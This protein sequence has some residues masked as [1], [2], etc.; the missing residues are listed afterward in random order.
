MVNASGRLALD[1]PAVYEALH[2]LQ[3]ITRDRRAYLP[4]M[5][6]LP[7]WDLVRFFSQDKVPM[8]L[9]GTYEWPR[10]QDE[11]EWGDTE[12]EVTAHLGFV[13]MPRPSLDVPMIGSL[14][15]TSW[16][17]LRQSPV[18]EICVEVLKLVAS[19]EASQAFC[20]EHLQISPHRSVNRRFCESNHPWL[21][22]IVPLLAQAKTRPMVHNYLQLSLFLRKMFEEVLWYGMPVEQT[23]Q[24]TAQTL[25]L[26][27]ER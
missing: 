19:A 15:G 13:M 18:Q 25:T 9:G 12:A 20:E 22:T 11:F 10:I 21:S 8:A 26:L 4:D 1:G 16:A 6:K 7:V 23:V 24:R 3:K 2:F 17:I 14:G 27:L 5:S